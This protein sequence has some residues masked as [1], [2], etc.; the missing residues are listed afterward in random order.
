MRFHGQDILLMW[1]PF[2]FCEGIATMYGSG[3]EFRF[4]A[5]EA[6]QMVSPDGLLNRMNS[7][8]IAHLLSREKQIVGRSRND[9]C[10]IL[11]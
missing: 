1:K 4:R 8:F 2:L 7:A 5:P 6:S 10:T 9:V 11:W 3:Y